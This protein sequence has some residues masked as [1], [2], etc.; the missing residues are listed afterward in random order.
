MDAVIDMPVLQMLL[1]VIMFLAI[2]VEIKTGG[3]G[4]G[5]LL[6]LVAAGV[7]WG[8]Q[9]VKG[10]VSLYQIAIFMGGIICI[11]AWAEITDRAVIT[12]GNYERYFT[13]ADGRRYWH[14][15]DPSNGFPADRGLVSVT[16]IG[17][18]GAECDA[19]STA[20]FVEG[21]E[22]AVQHWRKSGDFEM[23][24]VTSAGE[25]LLT[26]GIA[27]DYTAKKDMPCRVVQR[28]EEP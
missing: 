11:I 2:M 21:T 23:I 7:F 26:E 3:M 9:Y 10:L 14:I 16:V 13:G 27:A 28:D 8:S 24:L 25:L 1:L 18:C 15:L 17:G 5:I 22:Q 20:L 4:A 12:S 6:G 19:L